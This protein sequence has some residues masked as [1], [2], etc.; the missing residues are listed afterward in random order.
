MQVRVYTFFFKPP[1]VVV[2]RLKHLPAMWETWVQSLGWEDPLEKEMATQ[3]QYSCLVNPTDGG[4]WWATVHG[5]A[6]SQTRLSDLTSLHFSC[7]IRES[8]LTPKC[9]QK[10]AWRR[11]NRGS[12]GKGTWP[13]AQGGSLPAL[14][15]LREPRGMG[16]LARCGDHLSVLLHPLPCVGHAGLQA[17]GTGW[18]ST[19]SCGITDTKCSRDRMHHN[20]S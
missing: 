20:M 19:H 3:L 6:K 2:Q 5:V 11:A 16:T 18:M 10:G 1:K 8:R 7:L 12:S 14:D 4:A 17:L 15:T 9:F 13:V